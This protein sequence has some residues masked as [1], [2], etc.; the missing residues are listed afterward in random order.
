MKR[1]NGCSIELFPP[2]LKH[3][4]FYLLWTGQK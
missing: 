2:R 4:K 3:S 1:I